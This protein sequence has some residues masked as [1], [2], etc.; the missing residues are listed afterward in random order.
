MDTVHGHCTDTVRTL[1]GH[2]MDTVGPPYICG[3]RQI[4]RQEKGSQRRDA[5]V[6]CVSAEVHK[7]C[8]T[9]IALRRQFGRA[10]LWQGAEKGLDAALPWESEAQCTTPSQ[11][12]LTTPQA[13]AGK[14]VRA[15]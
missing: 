9:S 12:K 5:R 15:C 14:C 11:A 7:L 2:C 4:K 6:R 13:C 10:L 3:C 1:Y 8:A